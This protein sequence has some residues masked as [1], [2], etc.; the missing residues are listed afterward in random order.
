MYARSQQ[1]GKPKTLKTNAKIIIIV[2]HK[3]VC[4]D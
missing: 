1:I 4:K 3:A 2:V